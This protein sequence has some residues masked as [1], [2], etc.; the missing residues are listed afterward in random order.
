LTNQSIYFKLTKTPWPITENVV[1]SGL[2]VNTLISYLYIN[3]SLTYRI[4]KKFRFYLEGWFMAT[5]FVSGLLLT[6]DSQAEERSILEGTGHDT[7]SSQTTEDLSSQLDNRERGVQPFFGYS[8]EFFSVLDGGNGT[9][10]SWQGLADYGADFNLETLLGIRGGLVHIHGQSIQGDDPSEF[11][12]YINA[13]S[14]IVAFNTTRLFQVW[15]EQ[16]LMEGVN[17]TQVR[18]H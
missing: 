12:G 18:A 5:L 1:L 9:G 15:Y 8:G 4:Q 17:D 16:E 6:L 11:V 14:N 3:K 10:T 13:L 2:T 7:T